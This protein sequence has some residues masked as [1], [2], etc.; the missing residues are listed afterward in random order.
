MIFLAVELVIIGTCILISKYMLE[1]RKW[2]GKKI[3]YGSDDANTINK[4]EE[5]ARKIAST[6]KVQQD[7]AID[8]YDIEMSVKKGLVNQVKVKT[9][10]TLLILK[11]DKGY[12]KKFFHNQV[13]SK[14][15]T[16]AYL[17]F[18][19]WGWIHM[20]LLMLVLLITALEESGVIL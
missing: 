9:Q 20:L 16:I 3:V 14:R 8:E 19:L 1:K 7:N 6:G 2:L 15:G 10:K 18:Y 13:F 5:I 11:C 17:S 12:Y 4:M